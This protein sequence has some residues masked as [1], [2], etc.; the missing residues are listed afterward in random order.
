MKTLL[1]AVTLAIF[2]SA[3]ANAQTIADVAR[4]ERAKKQA[5]PSNTVVNNKTLGVKPRI[6][7]DGKPQESQAG[8]AATTTPKPAPQA[9]ATSAPSPAPP[10]APP[11]D[12]PPPRDEKWWRSQFEES[13]IEVRRAENQV[14][15]A[16]LELNAANRDF[17]TRS[18]D[19]DN[20]GPAAVAAAT[21]KLD[22]ANKNLAASRAKV[23]LLEEELRRAGAP[24]G[25]AR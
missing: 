2:S 14:A 24:A 13:R 5:A 9:A 20:R 3:W 4:Q 25:W 21:K 22:D 8:T 11:A 10:A 7:I 12:Q 17:L 1:C 6:T 18:F 23:S 16:Q 19:P 15:V